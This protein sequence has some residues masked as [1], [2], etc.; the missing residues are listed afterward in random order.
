MTA[1]PLVAACAGPGSACGPAGTPTTPGCGP[2][3]GPGCGARPPLAMSQVL[4]ATTLV[5]ANRVEG[6][7]VAYQ[8]AF[9]LF[10]LPHALLAHPVSPPSTPGWRPRRSSAG[11]RPSPPPSA[12]APGTIVFWTAPATALLVVLGRARPAR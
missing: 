2:S 7:V 11:G 10:L 5:L 3:A 9:T 6:G 1:V 8:I 4:L 12:G